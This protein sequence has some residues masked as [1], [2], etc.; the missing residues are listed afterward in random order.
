MTGYRTVVFNL[1]VIVLV[2]GLHALVGTDLTGIFGPTWSVV[3]IAG[4]NFILRL[5]T[6]TAVGQKSSA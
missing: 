3:I 2:G 1:L 4:A 5:V 6:T